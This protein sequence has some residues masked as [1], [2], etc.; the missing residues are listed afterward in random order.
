MSEAYSSGRFPGSTET[1]LEVEGSKAN[2]DNPPSGCDG[3]NATPGKDQASFGS[4]WGQR[5]GFVLSAAADN[6]LE[7]HNSTDNNTSN[8][9]LMLRDAGQSLA[10]TLL[11]Q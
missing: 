8:I 10:R 9:E 3:P 11:R 4:N 1:R 2:A 5:D 6:S 7:A